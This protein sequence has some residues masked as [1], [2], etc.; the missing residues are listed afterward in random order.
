MVAPQSLALVIRQRGGSNL[1]VHTRG[2]PGSIAGKACE[3]AVTIMGKFA[4]AKGNEEAVTGN[5]PPTFGFDKLVVA[6]GRYVV[7]YRLVNKVWVMAVSPAKGNLFVSIRVVESATKGLVT[8]CQTMEIS[9]D[10]IRKH[11]AES[12]M[13]MGAV[14]AYQGASFGKAQVEGLANFYS[15]GM[16]PKALKKA[17]SA[18]KPGE[19]MLGRRKL[20]PVSSMKQD[21]KFTMPGKS[22]E[23]IE[24]PAKFS[25]VPKI[26][27]TTSEAVVDDIDFDKYLED[28]GKQRKIDSDQKNVQD[29]FSDLP[30]LTIETTAAPSAPTPLND[31]F[32]PFSSV[33]PEPIALDNQPTADLGIFH[34]EDDA[35]KSQPQVQPEIPLPLLLI[36]SWNA[37]FVG[38]TLENASVVGEV[39]TC[40]KSSIQPNRRVRFQLKQPEP[41]DS[42]LEHSLRSARLNKGVEGGGG[43]GVFEGSMDSGTLL[44][45]KLW[46]GAY[47]QP[48]AFRMISGSP[49]GGVHFSDKDGGMILVIEYVV[50]PD[51]T[52]PASGFVDVQIP[53]KWGTPA[54]VRPQPQWSAKQQR[55][56]WGLSIQPGSRGV[57]QAT[58]PPPSGLD[59]LSSLEPIVKPGNGST[60]I[61]AEVNLMGELGGSLSGTSLLQQNSSSES[62]M[63]HVESS[64]VW[65]ASIK[66]RE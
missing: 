48:I 59:S 6:Q 45:Y 13:M 37:E 32:D 54:S 60:G 10:T 5:K 4:A 8:A 15:L 24:E 39:A 25:S 53:Q 51:L 47:K 29:P 50:N 44:K 3:E 43:K 14:L 65:R 2:I 41:C 12:Y 56:R 19:G 49:S 1:I 16:D 26:P 58:F 34:T 18:K 35:V 23:A 20:A 42:G 64:C 11:Y 61:T 52:A 63:T 7:V 9:V 27:A 40:P 38:S 30:G 33:F 22:E 17:R 46:P 55:L 28:L 21:M 62:E 31:P 66:L 57:M 36:E